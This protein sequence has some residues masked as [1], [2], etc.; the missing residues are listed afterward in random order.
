MYI[1]EFWIGYALGALSSL[2]VLVGIAFA[3]GK[4]KK[5]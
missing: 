4:K 5:R 3:Y 1:P 2:A